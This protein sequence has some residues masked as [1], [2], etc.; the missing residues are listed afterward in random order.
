MNAYPRLHVACECPVACPHHEPHLCEKHGRKC[1]GMPKDKLS[2]C[3]VCR[4][5]MRANSA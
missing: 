2:L 1:A 4:R 3:N 5:N